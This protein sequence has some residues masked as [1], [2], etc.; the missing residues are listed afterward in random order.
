MAPTD[1]QLRDYWVRNGG[2]FHGPH[3]ETGSMPESTLLP[4]LR[5]HRHNQGLVD[6]LR[7]DVEA[8]KGELDYWRLRATREGK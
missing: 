6:R 3:V 8:L 2:E 1:E 5:E 4:I 7:R